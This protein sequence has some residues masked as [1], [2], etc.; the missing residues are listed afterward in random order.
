MLR[1][2]EGEHK[3]M[4]AKETLKQG[5]SIFDQF[6]KDEYKSNMENLHRTNQLLA[7]KFM[8]FLDL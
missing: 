1:K 7:E 6:M 3:M 4:I 2:E 8:Q 5:T